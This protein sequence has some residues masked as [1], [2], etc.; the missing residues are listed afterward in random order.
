MQTVQKL[1]GGPHRVRDP[2]GTAVPA[3]TPLGMSKVMVSLPDELLTRVDNEAP[4]RQSQRAPRSCGPPRARLPRSRDDGRGSRAFR[5]TFCARRPVRQRRARPSRS[6]RSP[7]TS[8]LVD[9]SVLIKWFHSTGEAELGAARALRAA[10]I[11]NR[12]DAH[13]LDLAIYE[14]GNVLVRSLR[15]PA[16]EVADQLDDLLAIFG[17]PL[18]CGPDWLRDAAELA[19]ARRLSFY[20]A[21]WAAAARGARRALGQCRPPTPGRWSGGIGDHDRRTAEPHRSRRDRDP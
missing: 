9:T 1:A 21:A 11:A 3:A 13:I 16:N 4:L 18:L 19:A 20:D 15:W 12:I 2:L 14:L 5:T 17:T 8:V 7:L 10:H 6:R